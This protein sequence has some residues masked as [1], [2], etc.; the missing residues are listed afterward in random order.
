MVSDVEPPPPKDTWTVPLSGPPAQYGHARGVVGSATA[1]SG[2]PSPLKSPVARPSKHLPD[3]GGFAPA[4]TGRQ[5]RLPSPWGNAVSRRTAVP[6][7]F[8]TY[9]WG[10]HSS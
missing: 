9:S 3:G 7:G 1:T 8:T 6:S 10:G 4:G 5:D 2:R